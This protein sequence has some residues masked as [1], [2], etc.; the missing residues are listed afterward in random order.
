MNNCQIFDFHHSKKLNYRSITVILSLSLSILFGC[1]HTEKVLV[2]PIIDLKAYQT[3]GVIDFSI[4]ADSDLR[5]YVTQHYIQAVQS[6]QPGVRL[7]ELGSEEHVL[8]TVSRKQL[9]LAAIKS[10]GSAYHVDALISGHF[11]A[12][13][14]KPNVRLSSTWRS[15]HAG[16]IVEASLISKLWE[17]DSG[18]TLWTN[19]TLKKEQVASL[20]AD[21]NGNIAFGASD[22]KETY[23]NLVPELVYSN[24][25]DFRPYYVY[26]KVK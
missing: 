22:P 14:P 18:V 26:R 25:T 17:T 19:S 5:E 11:S 3:I 9:D 12:S 6:A 15:M 16:A 20:K 8:K 7:L 10:I 21:T 2:S 24:T 23:G 13:E 4:T 1:S